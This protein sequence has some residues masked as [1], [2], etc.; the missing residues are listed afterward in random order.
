MKYF[1]LFLLIQVSIAQTPPPPGQE[2]QCRSQLMRM[3]IDRQALNEAMRNSRGLEEHTLPAIRSFVGSDAFRSAFVKDYPLDPVG[4]PFN[5]ELCEREKGRD[6]SF[7]NVD[8]NDPNLCSNQTLSEEVKTRVCFALPCSFVMGNR[9]DRCPSNASARPTRLN[10][11]SPISLRRL[12]MNPENISIQNNQVHSC[13]VINA[14][15]LNFGVGIDFDNRALAYD[16]IGLSN[17]NLSLDSPRRVCMSAALDFTKN[18]PLQHVTLEPAPGQPFVSDA[19]IDRGLRSAGVSGLSG[20]S[21]AT[22]EILKTTGLPPLA[23]HFRPTIETA[24]AQVL[25]ST[26]ESS[27]GT[28]L[29]TLSNTAGPSRVDTPSDSMI[30]ELGVG[31]L[32]VGKYVDLLDCALM[33]KERAR[34]PADHACFTSNYTGSNTVHYA[35]NSLPTP[36]QA[37]QKLQQSLARNTNVTSETLRARLAAMEPR[38]RAQRLSP[39]YDRSVAPIVSAIQAAQSNSTLLHGIELVG[40]LSDSPQLSVGFCLP[41]ICSQERPSAHEGRS[42]PNCP[43][44][45]YVDINELNSLMR[46]MY[47]S[48]RL[49][50]RGRGDFVPERDSRGEIIRDGGFARGQ[51]CVLAI[52]DDPDGLRCYLNGP[53]TLKFDPATRRYN[54][55]M[56]TRE[57][58]RGGVFIGQGK[59]GGDINFSIGFTPSICNGGDFC[60]ENGQANWNVVPGTARYALRDSSW[61]NGIVRGRIDDNLREIVSSTLRFPVSS[62]QGPLANLPIAPEGRVDIGDGYF[63]ACLKIR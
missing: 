46:A 29:S 37:V 39:L 1:F 31:N 47:D 22:I 56:R 32:M 53:P 45:T 21:P 18:P 4:F 63:G 8:C 44:Q 13:F 28:Y 48:G 54:V 51:G 35:L 59:I 23:R 33:K 36:E 15:D 2:N 27:V 43:I 62:T 58:Y 5:K 38:M 14:M 16:Q 57:C 12:D 11:T 49:C 34:I 30:S 40:Q 10:F 3:D 61:M 26:F 19:M 24:I 25:G 17:L 52:E 9:M 41:E 42:I 6:P 20:Y 55:D 60:L 7:R 50:N